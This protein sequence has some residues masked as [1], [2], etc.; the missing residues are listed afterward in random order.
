MYAVVVDSLK[1]HSPTPVSVSRA[2]VSSLIVRIG[3]LRGLALNFQ[4]RRRGNFST[5]PMLHR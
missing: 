1:R 2:E 4:S 3:L 5:S